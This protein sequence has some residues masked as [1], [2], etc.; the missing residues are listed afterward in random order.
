M[1][2][3]K[4]VS[5]RFSVLPLNV[6]PRPSPLASRPFLFIVSLLLT[7]FTHA[8]SPGTASVD[9]KTMPDAVVWVDHLRYGVVP[10]TGE[11]TIA[12]LRPGNHSV[13][14]RLKGKHEVSR[15][16][17]L[18]ANE[19]RA[20][21][22]DLSAPADKAEFLF[23]VAEELR[24][25]GRQSDAIERYKAAIRLRPRGLIGARLGIARSMQVT[26]QYTEAFAHLEAAMREAGGPLPE[27]HTISGNL[28]R[29]QGFADAAIKSYETALA[30]ARG[31]WPEAH[32]GLALVNQDR[33][34]LGETIYHLNLA[35][36]QSNNTQ[37]VLYF[38]LANVFEREARL[39]EA[40]DAYEKYL[41][42]A[43]EGA[44]SASARSI[45]KQL[46]REIR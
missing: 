37:P 44:Q 31:N 25:N 46:R 4:I 12:N 13:R 2:L 36:M 28:K 35:I 23:Q 45:V 42:L 26:D 32:T 30:Q 14:A 38:L 15:A 11:L 22:I 16:F 8:Q 24:E 7:A 21:S 3:L 33:N 17:T 41:A 40:V 27:A 19:R 20:V 6:A 10:A 29:A 5:D 34:Q 9:I 1:K 18:S 43:P 39:K